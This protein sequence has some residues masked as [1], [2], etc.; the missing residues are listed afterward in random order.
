[1]LGIE[2]RLR[3]KDGQLLWR[4]AK[5]IV[6]GVVPNLLHVVPVGDDAM[7]DGMTALGESSPAK[8]ALHIPL[9]LSMTQAVGSSSG[10]MKTMAFL[11][12]LRTL[13]MFFGIYLRDLFF[14]DVY[15]GESS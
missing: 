3:E 2:G 12:V 11:S 8:P 13:F 15:I 5:L 9:P 14:V 10:Y 6:E 4:H 7:L 1:V